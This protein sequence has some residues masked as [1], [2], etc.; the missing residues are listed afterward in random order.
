MAATN[1]VD[2][3]RITL[4]NRFLFRRAIQWDTPSKNTVTAINKSLYFD[5]DPTVA[6]PTPLNPSDAKTS[7]P[8]QA[9][10]AKNAETTE[11]ILAS[12]SF[13]ISTPFKP[14]LWP[15]SDNR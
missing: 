5:I 3:H 11:L 2:I 4:F 8:S 10:Q 9:I 6:K 1:T 15:F 12:F 14:S 7:G 13:N